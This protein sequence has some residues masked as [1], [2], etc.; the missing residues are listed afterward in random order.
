MLRKLAYIAMTLTLSAGVL[1]I[2]RADDHWWNRNGNNSRYDSR[3][4]YN[5]GLAQGQSD[6]ARGRSYNANRGN[7]GDS[8]YKQAYRDGYAAG[9]RNGGYYGNNSRYGNYPNYPASRYPNNYPGYGNYPN[10]YPYGSGPA[11]GGNMGRNVYN[12]GYQDGMLDGQRDVQTGHS[13]RPTQQDNYKHAD[14]GYDGRMGDKNAY[15]QT[16]RE[17]YMSGYQQGYNNR[18]GGYGRGRG[19]GY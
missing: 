10:N 15:K 19:W 6:A 14:R 16:Y 4:G 3:E 13:Y 18:G 17:G 11:Y 7:H 12:T 2:A 1:T 8:A 5:A 9:Y